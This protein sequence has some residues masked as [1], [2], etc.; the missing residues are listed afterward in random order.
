MNIKKIILTAIGFM[1]LTTSVF[2]LDPLGPPLATSK[3][4]VIA[5]AGFEYLYGEMDL[6]SESFTFTTDPI[7]PTPSVSLLFSSAKIKNIKT[8]KFYVNF[9]P[10]IS[11]DNLDIFFR[12]GIA[13]ANPD[14]STNRDN[15]AGNVGYSDHD[16]ALGGG[17]RTTFYQSEDGI[18]K[19]GLLAQFSYTSLDFDENNYSVNGYDVSLSATI[20]M[21]EIQLAAGP[22]YNVTDELSI[23]GGPFL[24]FVKGNA[25]I[26]GSIDGESADGKCDLKQE[27]ELGGFIGLSTDLAK[28]TKFNI[29]YQLTAD[30]Q[31]VGFRFIHRF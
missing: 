23:Y 19:W 11:G 8:N 5:I 12:L 18:E 16:I 7:P 27:S 1:F 13:D 22:T 6:H 4:D 10:N 28:N 25:E 29:E 24:Q 14:K 30:A 2:A 3:K 9:I 26:K 15:L 21:L 20:D 17:I 31:A